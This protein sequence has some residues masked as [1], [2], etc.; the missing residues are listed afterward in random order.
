MLIWVYVPF[1]ISLVIRT[2]GGSLA[3]TID[4]IFKDIALTNIKVLGHVAAI[5][6]LLE[7]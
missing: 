6:S 4:L 5:G 7:L 1:P 3:G 2:V